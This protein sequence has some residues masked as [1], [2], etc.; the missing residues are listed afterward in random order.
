MTYFE[1]TALPLVLIFEGSFSA[2]PADRGGRTNRGITQTVYD[3]YRL[4]KNLSTSDVRNISDMEVADIYLNS[5]WLPSKCDQMSDK[6]GLV[7]FDS[8]VNN[9][10]GRSIKFLQQ[11][12]GIKTDG[13]IGLETISKMDRVDQDQLANTFLSNRVNFYQAIVNR[14]PTQTKFLKGWLRRINFLRDFISGVKTL[15][16]IRTTW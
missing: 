4:N 5:Y 7:V 13:I 6:L 3:K 14:D 2:D 9:G 11:S 12:M 1:S 8:S 10:Q 15:D 16:Q